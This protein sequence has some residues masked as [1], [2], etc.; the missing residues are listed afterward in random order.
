MYIFLL[1]YIFKS[2]FSSVCECVCRI[3]SA[4]CII[5]YEPSIYVSSVEKVFRI[6]EPH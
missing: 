5:K 2:A 1:Y 4:L 6:L 3:I